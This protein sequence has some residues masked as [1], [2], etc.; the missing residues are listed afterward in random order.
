MLLTAEI[1]DGWHLYA[2]EETEGGPFAT[3]IKLADNS[4]FRLAGS[5]VSPEASVVFDPNF[6]QDVSY[7]EN[8]QVFKL[9]VQIKP[10]LQP[11]KKEIKVQ[12][13]YQVCSGMTCHAPKQE[14]VKIEVN[15]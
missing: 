1:Q 3:Q 2:T 15:L 5:I 7:Y 14:N 13:K 11:G 8:T 4:P 12:V 10:D 6:E 9:P